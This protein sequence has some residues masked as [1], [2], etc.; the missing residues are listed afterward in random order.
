MLPVPTLQVMAGP[1]GAGKTA[2]FESTFALWSSQEFVNADRIAADIWPGNEL[3]HAYE[4]SRLA[5]QRR[6]ELFARRQSFVTETVF[7]HESKISM[8]RKALNIGY[9]VTLHVVAIP[10]DLAVARVRNRVEIGGHDVPEEKIRS[11]HRRLWSHVA[12]AAVLCES[13]YIYDN[14]SASSPFREIAAFR[15]GAIVQ[16]LPWPSWMPS[17]LVNLHP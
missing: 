4:A 11:R 12:E 15:R 8:I 1:N 5:A 13:A 6:D 10:E 3:E 16:R 2:L 14:T 9:I 17:E 7:S